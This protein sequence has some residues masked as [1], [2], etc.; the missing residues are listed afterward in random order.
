MKK[1]FLLLS[2]V[3]LNLF[4]YL[5]FVS[6]FGYSSS[7]TVDTPLNVYPGETKQAQIELGTVPNEGNL[8]IKAEMLDSAGIAN[9]SDSNLEYE[10][11]PGKNAIVNIKL[12]IPSNASIGEYSIKIK[13]SDIT[14]SEG[15]G[16]VGIKG[17]MIVSLRAFVIEKPQPIEEKISLVWIVLW[18]IVV[19]AAT[20]IIYFI[21]KSKK[22]RKMKKINFILSITFVNVYL[23][24]LLV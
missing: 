4:I 10:I 7:Y 14:P 16:T 12:K 3:L 21:V 1:I 18:L 22:S 5:N 2:V 9:F 24:K 8:T 15:E 17:G 6:A 11:G 19:A 13:F 23:L 20:A